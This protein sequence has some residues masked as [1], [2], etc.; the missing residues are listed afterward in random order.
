MKVTSEKMVYNHADQTVTFEGQVVV[1]REDFQLTAKRIVVHLL[2]GAGQPG[3]STP[4]KGPAG[5]AVQQG[6]A[7]AESIDRIECFGSVHMVREGKTGD[8]DNAVYQVAESILTMRGNPVLREGSNQ[9]QGEI[10]KFYMKENRSEVLGGAKSKV[11]ATFTT[12]KGM[13]TP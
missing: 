5:A 13:K 10:I 9:I 4:A 8:C 1:V 7:P 6:R 11:E 12:P 2:Q 3:A